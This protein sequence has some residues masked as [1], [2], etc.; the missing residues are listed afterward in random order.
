[1]GMKIEKTLPAVEHEEPNTTSSVEQD[2]PQAATQ[3]VR[4]EFRPVFEGEGRKPPWL[5]D[6]SKKPVRHL[7]NEA[8]QNPSSS[9]PVV[10]PIK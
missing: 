2:P 5:S 3:N 4:E 9:A 1:M 8:E 10:P 6:G 7:R